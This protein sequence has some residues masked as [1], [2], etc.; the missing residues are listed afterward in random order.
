MLRATGLRTAQHSTP[1]DQVS[2]RNRDCDVGDDSGVST[3]GPWF[4]RVGSRAQSAWSDTIHTTHQ[5][6]DEY[7]VRTKGELEDAKGSQWGVEDWGDLGVTISNS[8]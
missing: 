4:V 2:S 5:G 8:E 7:L 6:D 3:G 1:T